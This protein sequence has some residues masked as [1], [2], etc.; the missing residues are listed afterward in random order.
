MLKPVKTNLH[1]SMPVDRRNRNLRYLLSLKDD[2]LLFPFR[3]E[4]GLININTKKTDVHWGWDSPFSQIR[5]TFTGHWLSAMAKLYSS[6]KDIRIKVRADYIVS[7]IAFCQKENGGE[8]AFPIPEKYLHW[9]KV[10]KKVW[11]PH[12]VCHKVMMGLLDMYLYA[13]NDQALGIVKKCADWFYA[14]TNEISRETMDDMMDFEETGG[15]ME[16]WADLYAITN[17]PKHR[18]LIYRYER[19]RLTKPIH[20]GI[21]VLTNRHANTTVPEIHG[22]ARAYEVTGDKRFKR[23]VE[24]YWKLAVDDRGSFVT[25]GQTS[26]EVWTPPGQQANRLGPLAQE[27]CVVYNMMRL[28]QYLYRWSGEAKY[29]DYYE[30]NLYNGIFAQGYW[31]E[32]WHST[33]NEDNPLKK[34]HVI[35]YLPLAPGSIK[36]WGSETE[37][38]W[39]CHCTLVQA[40]AMFDEHVFF[41]NDKNIY[42][43]QFLPS[44]LDTTV[45]GKQITIHQEPIRQSDKDI[46]GDIDRTVLSRPKIDKH[47]VIVNGA[48][49]QFALRIRLPWWLASDAKITINGD[50]HVFDVYDGHA[51]I[52][53]KWHN[54]VVCC[55]FPKELKAW[56]LPDEPKTVAFIEGPI[57]FAGLI[58]E[59]R[60]LYGDIDNP[61][62]FMTPS[63]E[64]HWVNWR[65]GWRTINQPVN[66]K[67]VPLY[68]IGYE[69]YTVYF[70]VKSGGN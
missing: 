50:E 52:N 21:D 20:D 4:A 8:W 55:I 40:N 18:E 56:S 66:F 44:S 14:F 42:I 32:Y 53:R 28:S 23:I 25:G 31:E 69:E 5:G 67:F 6:L 60:T 43:S 16:L 64:R 10:G 48:G 39:C 30:Q 12:Y 59:E 33:H 47:S 51:V 54:D 19:P 37:H 11:A 26:G 29:A 36:E 7:E 58:K 41:Q 2:N 35:Y 57:A 49:E 46:S 34:G 17:D 45:N 13:E 70:P 65:Q 38:F 15:I 62:S 1:N 24:N 27:L 61:E 9:I 68:D 3:Q 63:D 22:V